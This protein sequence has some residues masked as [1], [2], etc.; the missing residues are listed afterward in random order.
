MGTAQKEVLNQFSLADALGKCSEFSPLSD[1]NLNFIETA[2]VQETHRIHSD[3]ATLNTGKESFCDNPA[4]TAINMCF[5]HM[6]V[7]LFKVV[8]PCPASGIT[9]LGQKQQKTWAAIKSTNYVFIRMSF[10]EK[11]QGNQTVFFKV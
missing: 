8:L 3:N 10:H 4:K 6:S 2:S 11:R 9:H 5:V 7:H 1:G